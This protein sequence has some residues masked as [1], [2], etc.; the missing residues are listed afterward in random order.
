MTNAKLNEWT[1][2]GAVTDGKQSFLYL[3]GVL[4]Q[5]VD[6]ECNRVWVKPEKDGCRV[7]LRDVIEAP[8]EGAS[9]GANRA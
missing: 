8:K 9:R 7:V 1:D 4:V 3:N 5:T 6:G 2:V